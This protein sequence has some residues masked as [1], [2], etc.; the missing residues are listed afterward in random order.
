MAFRDIEKNT[1]EKNL[2][3][4]PFIDLEKASDR[5]NQENIWEGLK[6]RG[7]EEQLIKCVQS[8]YRETRNYVKTYRKDS[9]NNTKAIIMSKN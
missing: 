7:I 6:K 1:K 4:H 5:I 8:I 2:E 3:I 9:I